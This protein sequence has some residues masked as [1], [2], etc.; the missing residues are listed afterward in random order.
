MTYREPRTRTA[1]QA[2]EDVSTASAAP[3]IRNGPNGGMGKIDRGMARTLGTP[4]EPN[5]GMRKL[6]HAPGP[7]RPAR[8]GPKIRPRG[9]RNEPNGG[10]GKLA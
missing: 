3:T 7:P 1:P 5:G 2:Y 8:T 10:M 4:N 6:V 9:G